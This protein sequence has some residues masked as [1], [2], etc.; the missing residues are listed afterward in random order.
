M[1]VEFRLK[2]Y[3]LLS[4]VPVGC[5]LQVNTQRGFQYEV[6]KVSGGV[7]EAYIIFGTDVPFEKK[8]ENFYDFRVIHYIPDFC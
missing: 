3:Q 1:N 8:Q 2:Q 7:D 5:V 4:R 6:L